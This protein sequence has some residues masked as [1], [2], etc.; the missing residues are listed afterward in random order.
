MIDKKKKVFIMRKKELQGGTLL[1]FDDK[2]RGFGYFFVLAVG[3][4]VLRVGFGLGGGAEGSDREGERERQKRGECLN[5]WG[6]QLWTG[7]ICCC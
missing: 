3:F 2:V 7:Y 6:V 4:I 5:I 1:N